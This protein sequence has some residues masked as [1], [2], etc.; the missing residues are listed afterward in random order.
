MNNQQNKSLDDEQFV[1]EMNRVINAVNPKQRI[2]L[3]AELSSS[4]RLLLYFHRPLLEQLVEKLRHDLGLIQKLPDLGHPLM[5]ELAKM[6]A[7]AATTNAAQCIGLLKAYLDIRPY[8][9]DAV[10]KNI[11]A[12]QQHRDWEF[13]Q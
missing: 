12:E 9:V 1:S 4:L 2:Q 3:A 11:P 7:P 8:F 13:D 5:N 10:R 6:I